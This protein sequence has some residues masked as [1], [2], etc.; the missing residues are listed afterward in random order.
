MSAPANSVDT[1]FIRFGNESGMVFIPAGEFIMGANGRSQDQAPEHVVFLDAYYIDRYEVTNADYDDCVKGGVCRAPK[2]YPG[3]MEP[4]Q[5]V[6]GITWSDA[7]TWCRWAGKRLPTEAE[8]EKAARGPDGRTYPWG[9]GLSCLDAN[10]GNNQSVNGGI[11]E[12]P[13]NPSRTAAVGTAL[14]DISPY[15]AH[16]MAGN[17]WEYVADYYQAEYYS[18]SPYRNPKGPSSGS[19]HIIKGG[20]WYTTGRNVALSSR[21]NRTDASA[22][23]NFDGFRCARD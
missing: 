3:F 10:Y 8:W 23:N 4:S 9:E 6:I 13:D 19:T 5:P 20:S 14:R 17:A 2:S 18:S 15:G 16:D 21:I 11:H 7:D 12:C 22:P 1:R